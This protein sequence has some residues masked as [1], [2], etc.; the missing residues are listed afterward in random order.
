MLSSHGSPLALPA[1]VETQTNETAG[2]PPKIHKWPRA[3]TQTAELCGRSRCRAVGC[4]PQLHVAS[5]QN[6]VSGPGPP[7]LPLWTSWVDIVSFLPQLSM[8]LTSG[9]GHPGAGDES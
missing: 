5:M 4:G 7:P 2:P 9:V 8:G 6:L 1:E 3:A